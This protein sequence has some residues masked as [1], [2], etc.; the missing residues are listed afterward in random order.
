MARPKKVIEEPKEST[1]PKIKAY[2]IVKTSQTSALAYELVIQNGVVIEINQI[3][4]AP[5]MPVGPITQC[6]DKL[7]K[8]WRTQYKEDLGE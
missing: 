5:D 4:R 2:T 7:W 1:S 6:V 3:S 8:A